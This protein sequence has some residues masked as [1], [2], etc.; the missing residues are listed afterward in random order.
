MKHFKRCWWRKG[1]GIQFFQDGLES[2]AKEYMSA[3]WQKDCDQGYQYCIQELQRGKEEFFRLDEF[4]KLRQ[5]T[6]DRERKAFFWFF[7]SFF[8]VFAGQAHGIIQKQ[9][10]LF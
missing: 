9:N 5:A 10:S 8:S 7:N 6:T 4:C 2:E 3:V 1:L